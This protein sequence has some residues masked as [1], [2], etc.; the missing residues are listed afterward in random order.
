M[1]RNCGLEIDADINTCLNIAHKA[2]YSPP[3]QTR[4]EAYTPMCQGIID[5]TKKKDKIR[6]PGAKTMTPRRVTGS[7]PQ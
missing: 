3:T 4:I 7:T 5:L 6:Q 1:C 2:G